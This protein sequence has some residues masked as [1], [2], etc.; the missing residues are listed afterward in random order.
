V[1]GKTEETVKQ[2]HQWVETMYFRNFWSMTPD[3]KGDVKNFY[4][5]PEMEKK[6]LDDIK[7]L[8]SLKVATPISRRVKD[9]LII[10]VNQKE[11]LLL[12][13]LYDGSLEEMRY[14]DRRA[15]Q[16]VGHFEARF[17]HRFRETA[18]EISRKG[19]WWKIP[20]HRIALGATI[21]IRSVYVPLLLVIEYAERLNTLPTESD[22]AVP[23]AAF[24]L[25]SDEVET[26]WELY[27]IN[28]DVTVRHRSQRSAILWLLNLF[29]VVLL[30]VFSALLGEALGTQN[31][32]RD[33]FT[34]ILSLGTAWVLHEAWHTLS[35]RIL[36]GQWPTVGI[37]RHGF[38]VKSKGL[39]STKLVI[40]KAAFLSSLFMLFIFLLPMEYWSGHLL[41]IF[42]PSLLLNLS[43]LL[44]L[45][46]L[47]G[48]WIVPHPT[49][50]D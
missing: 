2:A 41:F 14:V 3:L 30:V 6:L 25:N 16:L 43:T 10:R 36:T 8:I 44:P 20:G 4:P 32:E 45:Q 24:N 40:E 15:Y 29:P 50:G 34:G 37:T 13:S 7:S 17:L 26:L 1:G 18:R 23:I 27:D 11:D 49:D 38:Y 5:Q 42:G 19:K 39:S 46:H 21:P 31:W 22:L 28:Q 12:V 48:P 35:G 47:L 9:N 33:L